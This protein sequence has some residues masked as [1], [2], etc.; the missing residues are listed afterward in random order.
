MSGLDNKN[1]SLRAIVFD[2]NISREDY[3]SYYRGQVK[4]VITKSICGKKVQFPANLLTS[5][6]THDGIQGRFVLQYL[7]SGKAV[8]LSK[9]G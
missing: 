5:H 9:K 1:D 6:V 7:A 4:W 8:K 3:L 2:L